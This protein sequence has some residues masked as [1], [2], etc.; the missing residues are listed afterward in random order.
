MLH[1]S[2]NTETH[3]ESETDSCIALWLAVIEQAMHDYRR[4]EYRA[5]VIYSLESQWG[6][7]ICR[8]AG[9]SRQRL[10]RHLMERKR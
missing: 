6:L 2:R 4:P 8:M 1:Q 7:E 3:H 5:E 10:V 9:I